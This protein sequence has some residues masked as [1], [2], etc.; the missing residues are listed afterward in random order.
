MMIKACNVIDVKRDGIVSYIDVGNVNWIII[1]P[2]EYSEN[3]LH[4]TL[5]RERKQ[6]KVC[7]RDEKRRKFYL[8]C[9]TMRKK[10]VSRIREE[11]RIDRSEFN[12]ILRETKYA[13]NDTLCVGLE[14]EFNVV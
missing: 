5:Q 9:V 14:C 1:F 2:T 13:N 12:S 6:Q 7:C 4:F 11:V 3:L 8:I 10:C